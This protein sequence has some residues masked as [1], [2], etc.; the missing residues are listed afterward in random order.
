MRVLL[1]DDDAL[2][3][4]GLALILGGTAGIEVI[5]EAADGI[6]A[7]DRVAAGGVDLVLMDIRMP[8][9]DGIDATREVVSLPDPPRVI[10]L[11]TFDADDHVVFVT[12]RDATP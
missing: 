12:R 5:G 1:A 6:E 11:T 3:R 7:L 8:N 9:L 2:V 10:V 4:A